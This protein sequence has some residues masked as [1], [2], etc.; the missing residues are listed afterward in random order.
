MAPPDDQLS[1]HKVTHL[2][3]DNRTHR[4]D[5]GTSGSDKKWENLRKMGKPIQ[6]QGHKG[7][8]KSRIYKFSKAETNLQFR[9]AI[10]VFSHES[11]DAVAVA[12]RGTNRI[13]TRPLD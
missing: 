11:F 5:P 9:K 4:S 10:L 3:R 12:K 6:K 2:V 8:S 13:K 7:M 1:L